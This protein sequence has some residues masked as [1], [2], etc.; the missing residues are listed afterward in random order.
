M[1]YNINRNVHCPCD[2]RKTSAKFQ[3]QEA[4]KEGTDPPDHKVL[5]ATMAPMV[6]MEHV[7]HPGYL[8]FQGNRDLMELGVS[9]E[10]EVHE[11]LRVFKVQEGLETSVL[12]FIRRNTTMRRLENPPTMTYK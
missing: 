11:A 6:A 9:M 2:F 10:Q 8:D 5:V 4:H 1:V 12:V 7:V 3:D